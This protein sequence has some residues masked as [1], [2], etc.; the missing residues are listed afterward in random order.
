MEADDETG[1]VE[2]MQMNGAYP[3]YAGGRFL[4]KTLTGKVEIR[5]AA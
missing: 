4:T 3:V 2:V 1:T 5:P